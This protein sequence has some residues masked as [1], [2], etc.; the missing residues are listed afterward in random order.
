MGFCLLLQ[1]YP[2]NLRGDFGG[3]HRKVLP[4]LRGIPMHFTSSCS[5]SMPILPY[6]RFLINMCAVPKKCRWS[7]EL[8]KATANFAEQSS[9]TRKL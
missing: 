4:S 6:D 5:E 9:W 3:K 7:P 1:G 8:R 2:I